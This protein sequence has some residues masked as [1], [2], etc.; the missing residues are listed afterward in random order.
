[1]RSRN[2]VV[3]SIVVLVMSV[4]ANGNVLSDGFESGGFANWNAGWSGVAGSV[5]TSAD[6]GTLLPRSGN[7]MMQSG[8]D[9]YGGNGSSLANTFGEVLVGKTFTGYMTRANEL[10][11]T[12]Q[13]ACIGVSASSGNHVS[14]RA[15]ELGN[16]KVYYG[17]TAVDTGLVLPAH[18][19]LKVSIYAGTEGMQVYINDTLYALPGSGNDYWVYGNDISKVWAGSYWGMESEWYYDDFVVTPE[20]ASMVLMGFGAFLLRK[21]YAA[22][23]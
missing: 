13:M 22:V 19:W 16:V 20:P 12:P 7:Y 17:Y 11:Q 6:G 18:E 3:S 15:D 2:V 8:D 5:V 9:P 4:L 23:K 14:V 10:S 21:R 1:M